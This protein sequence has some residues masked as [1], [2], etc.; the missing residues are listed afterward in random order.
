MPDLTSRRLLGCAR[1][2]SREPEGDR[3]TGRAQKGGHAERSGRGKLT[4]VTY[5]SR[6]VLVLQRSPAVIEPTGQC[7][8]SGVGLM[9]VGQ[10]ARADVAEPG[11]KVDA[12][13]GGNEDPLKSQEKPGGIARDVALVVRWVA[14]SSP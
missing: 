11:G 5:R 2:V 14:K 7:G 12:V 6:L 8:V 9:E 1:N 10:G 13:T 4:S 3:R